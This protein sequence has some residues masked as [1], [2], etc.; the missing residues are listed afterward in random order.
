[1]EIILRKKAVL[2]IAIGSLLV[3]SCVTRERVVYQQAPPPGV[4]EQVVIPEAPPPI[5]VETQ[6]LAPGPGFIWIGGAWVWRGQW[7]WTHGYWSRPPHPGAV[8]VPHRYQYR[9]GIHVYV[10]GYWR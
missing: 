8:W 7:I 3:T 9:N 2:F 5:I 1:M 10:Q 4:S 6:T